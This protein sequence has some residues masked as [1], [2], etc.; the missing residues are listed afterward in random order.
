MNESYE[1]LAQVR[2]LREQLK[3][4]ADKAG[5]GETADSIAALDKQAAELGGAAQNAF[6]GLP[7]SGQAA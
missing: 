7:S 2:S 6:F 5:K 4:R 3:E 1:A